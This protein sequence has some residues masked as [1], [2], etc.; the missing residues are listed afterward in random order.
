[1]LAAEVTSHAE[2]AQ[3]ERRALA[4]LPVAACLLYPFLLDAFHHVIG[5]AGASI[6]FMRGIAAA[7]LLTA[8][9][10]VPL[11][12]LLV[13]NH[14][15][16]LKPALRRLAFF[17]VAAP[18]LYVFLGVVNYMAASAYPDE[19]LW[20][21]LWL[22]VA[23]WARY[24]RGRVDAATPDVARGR[25]A[26]GIVALLVL[27]YIA[28]HVANHLLLLAGPDGAMQMMHAGEQVYRAR[29]LEFLLVLALL[30]MCASGGYLAWRWSAADTRHDFF[31]SFQIASGVYLLAYI[32]GHMD[33]V[34]VYARLFLDIPTDWKFATGA[35]AGMLHDAWNIRLLPHYAL[36]VFFVIAH[37]LTGLRGILLAHGA[38][39]RSANVMWS[40]GVTVAAIVAT[41]V[42]IG[43]CRVAPGVAAAVS[44]PA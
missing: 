10:V 44:A 16:A 6:G 7:L 9:F 41:A 5:L 36:G 24:G 40:V 43:M 32:V 12:G 29:A 18:T 37:P 11:V 31:R 4:L 13:A 35:P 30:F 33:S 17:V 28:F 22:G 42:I 19:V 3:G 27:A 8:V 2:I 38:Q 20:V 21:A 1:M 15:G 34:F 14:R 26:H 39:T 25:V 23:V